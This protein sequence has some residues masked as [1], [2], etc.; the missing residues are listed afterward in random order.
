MAAV[1]EN[2]KYAL[3]EAQTTRLNGGGDGGEHGEATGGRGNAFSRWRARTA[4]AML[5]RQWRTA[6]LSSLR[7]EGGEEKRNGTGECVGQARGVLKTR[8]RRQGAHS[9]WPALSGERRRVADTRRRAS[10]PVGHGD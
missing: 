9:A 5:G 10:E 7:A 3:T 1:G 2:G 8:L 6:E 4:V